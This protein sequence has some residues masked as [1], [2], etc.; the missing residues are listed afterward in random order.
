MAQ[1]NLTDIDNPAMQ[2]I[3]GSEPEPT[4]APAPAYKKPTLAPATKNKRVARLNLVLP[5]ENKLKLQKLVERNNYK[6]VNDYINYLVAVAV[7]N[8]AEP[9]PREIVEYEQAH[10]QDATGRRKR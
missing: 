2:F 5:V 9:S 3:S 1:K 4:P 10:P 8:E 7:A 6:S